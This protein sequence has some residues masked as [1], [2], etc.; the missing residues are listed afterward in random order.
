[1]VTKRS[2]KVRSWKL[3]AAMAVFAAAGCADVGSADE[4]GADSLPQLVTPERDPQADEPRKDLGRGNGSDVITIGDSWMSNTLG[5]GNAIEGALDRLQ[6]LHR[7]RH[8]ARQGVLLLEDSLFGPAIPNQWNDAVR[9]NRNIKT[10]IM[11]AGGN[12]VLQDP[13]AQDDCRRGGAKCKNTLKQ[14]GER[15][16]ALWTQ[17]GQAGVQDIVYVG[18]SEHAGKAGPDTSNASKNGVGDVCLSMTAVRCHLIEST[19]LVPA[20]EISGFDGI[21]PIRSANDRLAKTIVDLME[22]EGIRR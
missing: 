22:R 12:D 15:L 3:G 18:Y 19:P 17:M 6:P 1:M 2:N 8:Y 13:G 20:N 21:H 16:R 4:Q 11:T 9:Q 14:I 5:T 10:V 7:Y